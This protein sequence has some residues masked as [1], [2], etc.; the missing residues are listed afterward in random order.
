MEQQIAFNANAEAGMG[1]MEARMGR[2]ESDISVTKG[3]HVRTRLMDLLPDLAETLEFDFVR[4][5]P[6]EELI[7]TA[8]RISNAAPGELSS[9]R[10]ADLVVQV[11][12]EQDTLYLAVEASWTASQRDSDRAVRNADFLTETTGLSAIPVIASVRNTRE[13]ADLIESGALRWYRIEERD[14]QVE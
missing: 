11:A 6:R 5:I 4:V 14:V 9:F 7:Q 3:G 13:V 2:I 1:R 10:R 8:R 12:K